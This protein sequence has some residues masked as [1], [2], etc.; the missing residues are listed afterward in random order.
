MPAPPEPRA[1]VDGDERRLHPWSWLFV[2]LQQLRQFIVPL[3]VLVFLGRGD[4]YALWPLVGVA[5]LAAASIWRYFTYRYHV[6]GDRLVVRE[7]LLERQVRQIP[8]ARIHNVALHQTLLHRVFG[9]AEVRLE[10]AGG[11]KPEAEMRVLRMGEALA[12]ERLIRSHGAAA[13]NADPDALEGEGAADHA[14]G[15]L[16]LS[17]QG[18]ELVRLGLVSNRGMVVVAGAFAVSWQVLPDHMLSSVVRD[19]ADRIFGYASGFADGMMARA[20]AVALVV[21]AALALLRVLS[22]ALALLQ[23]HGFRL[24]LQGRRLTV[25]RGLLTRL[26]TSA[27]RRR[28]QSWSLRE[29]L[30][31]RLLRRRSLYIDTVASAGDGGEQRGLREL[32]P[33]ATP[34]A[35][36]A[37]VREVLA[38]A[39]PA[40]PPAGW[41]RVHP[42]TWQR[43]ALPGL[44]FAGMGAL[45]ACWYFGPAGLLALAWAPWAVHAARQNAQRAGY[46]LDAR[47]VAARWGWWSRQWRFAEIDKLQALRLE[48]SPL[49][50]WFGMATLS[51]D[52][53]GARPTTVLRLR[54]MP[55]VEARAL[56]GRLAAELSRLPLRW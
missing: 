27:P 3:L 44:M 50:R 54:F 45:A 20:A 19:A 6:D 42:R 40:W 48:Q 12:L 22:V 26:R 23:Y 47:M 14:D 25:E 15:R 43:L 4:R 31:H 11:N 36:D 10:S 37:L 38:G 5:V 1:P 52:T 32:A 35:C 51:L 49:D 24:L 29:G 17:L 53:A 18:V 33:I 56:H 46:A 55:E 34:E 8:F 2:L 7:G 30:L 41:R 13:A 39:A 28:I 21:I 16:L 9:V